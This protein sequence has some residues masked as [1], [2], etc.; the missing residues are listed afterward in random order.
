MIDWAK[1]A[2][3]LVLQEA[4]E[5][6]EDNVVTFCNLALFWH[7]EG[8]WRIALLHKGVFECDKSSEP[9]NDHYKG[10]LASSSTQLAWGQR[11]CDMKHP[12]KLKSDAAVSGLVI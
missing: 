1:R 10:M 3:K 7:A 9:K 5:L 8:S 12:F 4:E 2:G 11:S 6:H